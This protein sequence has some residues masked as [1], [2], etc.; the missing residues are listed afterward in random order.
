[1]VAD[2]KLFLMQSAMG[3]RPLLYSTD[4]A[5]GPAGLAGFRIGDVVTE[6][7]GKPA[8]AIHVYDLRDRL[9]HD[10][11]GTVVQFTVR[12]DGK[13]H[14]VAVTLRDQI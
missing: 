1:L 12:R 8:T 6:V 9:S 3:P 5:H 4:P 13:V 11:P 14:A 10:A 2:G 7:D